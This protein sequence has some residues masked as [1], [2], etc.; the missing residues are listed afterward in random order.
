MA[1]LLSLK[2]EVSWGFLTSF[3]K[4][5]EIRHLLSFKIILEQREERN[6][7]NSWN[8]Q[9]VI[10]SSAFWKQKCENLKNI[11]LTFFKYQSIPANSVSGQRH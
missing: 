2:G 4:N 11:S 9:L 6:Q 8:E 10:C 7:L 5:G 1:R 3:V